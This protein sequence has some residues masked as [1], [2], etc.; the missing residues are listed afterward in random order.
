M[1]LKGIWKGKKK[2]LNLSIQN[3]LLFFMIIL[4]I[5]TV[6]AVA[7]ISI[8][9]SKNMAIDLMQ[10][11]M[12]KE[13]KVVY[14]LAQNTRLS[15]ATD[16]EKF[17]KKMEQIIR[18]QDSDLVQ[19]GV[20]A[21][22]FLL[23][24]HE[25][26]PF[27]VSQNANVNI[28]DGIIERMEAEEAGV[29]QTEIEGKTYSVAFQN[30]Q[31]L[32][33]IY[34]LLVPQDAYLQK[35]NEIREV[36]IIVSA[37]S[38]IITMVIIIFFVRSIVKP[39]NM[40]RNVM[41]NAREGNLSNDFKIHTKIPEI[42]SLIL[43]YSTL[44]DYMK[45]VLIEMKSTSVDLN[46]TGAKLNEQSNI[47]LEKNSVLNEVI[48]IVKKGA[49]ETVSSSDE[50]ISVFREM[51]ETVHHIEERMNEMNEKTEIMNH[52]AKEGEDRMK[53]LLDSLH[54]LHVDFQSTNSTIMK[55]QDH[56]GSIGD[57]VNL[58]RQLAEQTKLLAL[59]ASLEAARA[60]VH[61]KGFAVVAEEVRKLAILSSDA[62][63]EIKA[64]TREMD[65]IAQTASD[66]MTT[67]NQKFIN[68]RNISQKSRM[69]F[70]HLL[71]GIH[72]VNKRLV[73][74]RDK[75]VDLQLLLP[76]MENT[77]VHLTSISQ[78]TLASAD[79]MKDI[80]ELQHEGVQTTVE[81]SKRLALLVESLDKYTKLFSFEK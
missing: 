16:D 24:E 25:V 62:A 42:N 67:I 77:S 26:T 50:N 28:P 10:Q 5:L 46:E 64:F 13:V 23:K 72:S 54:T 63:E 29:I 30:I 56:S 7:Y 61:G 65:N 44:I 9:K 27:K 20:E 34:T 19:D 3:R 33:G 4:L 53:D 73:D 70:D 36:I 12:E 76:K 31:E 78:Q 79:E 14:I 58:I 49:N 8:E 47:I 37:F 15:Y 71:S 40:L 69:A 55:I 74:N 38:V 48:H 52:A 43:S 32:K 21:N 22:Y 51:K 45:N 59:N 1:S 60:G 2:K 41:R 66:D 68:S 11:R 80:S 81:V 39:L 35:V 6:T 18:D 57:I 17:E 75:L